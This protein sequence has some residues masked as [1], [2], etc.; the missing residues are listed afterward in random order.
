LEEYWRVKALSRVVFFMWT[1]ALGK[2]LTFDNQRKRTVI[3]MD[4]CCM[5]KK[6]GKSID[7]FLLH[8]EVD[9]ELWNLLV[10]LFGVDLAMPRRVRKLLVSLRVRWEAIKFWKFG[11][12]LFYV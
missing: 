2:I 4:W 1:V 12:W 8:Y 3:V 6:S 10:H 5:Y 11:G 9:R 7:H